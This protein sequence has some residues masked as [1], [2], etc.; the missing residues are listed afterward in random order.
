MLQ[1]PQ[2]NHYVTNGTL[3]NNNTEEDALHSK[4]PEAEE[5]STV[6]A[7]SKGDTVDIAAAP[8]AADIGKDDHDQVKERLQ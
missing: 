2:W 6:T 4:G 8:G 1:Y 3:V 5:E 7:D